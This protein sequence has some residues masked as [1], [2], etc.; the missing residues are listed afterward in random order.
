MLD[1]VKNHILYIIERFIS[2]YESKD[3][4]NI[5]VSKNCNEDFN[6]N[7][8]INNQKEPIISQTKKD[9]NTELT[10]TQSESYDI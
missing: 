5:S 10:S 7:K 1:M 4:K 6:Y 8:F 2:Y 9:S 3:F